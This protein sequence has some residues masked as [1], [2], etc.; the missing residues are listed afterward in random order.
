[1]VL[2][3]N[4]WEPER[5]PGRRRRPRYRRLRRFLQRHSER[6]HRGWTPSTVGGIAKHD[7]P[8][9][10]GG[11]R[12]TLVR[13]KLPCVLGM[14]TDDLYTA[15]PRGWLTRHTR[16]RLWSCFRRHTCGSRGDGRGITQ[17]IPAAGGRLPPARKPA[18]GSG[19]DEPCR[20]TGC[21][22][23]G[24]ASGVSTCVPHR[25]REGAAFSRSGSRRAETPTTSTR[26][27]AHRP[28]RAPAARGPGASR[29]RGCR[30]T[31]PRRSS[32]RGRS[33]RT[34]D[35]ERPAPGRAAGRSATSE[36][37]RTSGTGSR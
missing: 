9:R 37:C 13:W 14:A 26:R 11:N 1:M 34:G 4:G 18:L 16:P 17:T 20:P 25:V 31:R 21:P 8:V 7:L 6:V 5:S 35:R 3:R 12:G 22:T 10:G 36:P 28:G 32:P 2:V 27:P 23:A 33:V 24:T 29:A 15:Y 30:D 19:T